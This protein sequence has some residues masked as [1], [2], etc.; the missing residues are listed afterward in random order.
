MTRPNPSGRQRP[1]G[2]SRG[3]QPTQISDLLPDILRQAKQDAS[4]TPYQEAL[5]EVLGT[6]HAARCAVLRLRSGTLTIAVD[7]APLLAE[8]RAFRSEELREGI[9]AHLDTPRVARIVFRPAGT[10]SNG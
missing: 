1:G 5:E 2:E 9:N 6:E 3:G 4:R 8:L 7:S 10:I